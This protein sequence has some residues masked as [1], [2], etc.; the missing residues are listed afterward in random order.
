MDTIQQD[1]EGKG[2]THPRV[3]LADIEAEIASEF[4][5][6]AGDGIRGESELSTS[7]ASWT[8]WDHVTFCALILKNGTKLIG[9]NYGP[10]SRSDFDPLMARNF[11]RKAAIGQIWPLLGFRLRDQLA[12][13][14]L[15]DADAA[16]DLAG[17]PRPNWR[18]G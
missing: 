5:F 1:I 8:G 6:T 14:V 11:A 10:V 9:V 15:T 12:R 7:P 16:A 2:L 18:G 17:M 4:Y 13:G 3:T